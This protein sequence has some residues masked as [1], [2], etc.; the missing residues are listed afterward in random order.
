MENTA[1][2]IMLDAARTA[3]STS[4]AL[5]FDG[6]LAKAVDFLREA[7]AAVAVAEASAAA[8]AQFHIK[9]RRRVDRHVRFARAV[10]RGSQ[11]AVVRRVRGGRQ[12]ANCIASAAD[13]AQLS[14]KTALDEESATAAVK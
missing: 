13:W 12:A 14:P 2:M 1:L 7:M 10:L 3:G 6:L 8:G 11:A 5:L 9:S 4:E